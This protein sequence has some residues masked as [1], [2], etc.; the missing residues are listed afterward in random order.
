LALL[1]GACFLRLA[2]TTLRTRSWMSSL[3]RASLDQERDGS[4]P[5]CHK[6]K[7]AVR[8]WLTSEQNEE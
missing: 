6:A 7:N 1:G 8:A 4:S 3:P 2:T 5:S